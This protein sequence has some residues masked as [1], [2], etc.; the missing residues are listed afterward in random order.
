M[1]NGENSIF[2]ELVYDTG[3]LKSPYPANA[4]FEDKINQ[5]GSTLGIDFIPFTNAPTLAEK[6]MLV[7]YTA[8]KNPIDNKTTMG[9]EIWSSLPERESLP[10]RKP[11]KTVSGQE[12][13]VN[14]K[15][16]RPEFWDGNPETHPATIAKKEKEK[17]DKIDEQLRT[18]E[19]QAYQAKMAAK[20]PKGGYFGGEIMDEDDGRKYITNDDGQKG[21]IQKIEKKIESGNHVAD[22]ITWTNPNT[23]NVNQLYRSTGFTHTPVT[24]ITSRFNDV[25]Q[26]LDDFTSPEVYQEMGKML[27]DNP[28]VHAAGDMAGVVFD[29]LRESLQELSYAAFGGEHMSGKSYNEFMY[30]EF[31][32]IDAELAYLDEREKYY[33]ASLGLSPTGADVAVDVGAAIQAGGKGQ[34]GDVLSSVTDVALIGAAGTAKNTKKLNAIKK[35]KAKLKTKKQAK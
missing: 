24:F 11:F 23:G 25:V 13:N 21:Y 14:E 26:I 19:I 8:E 34:I 22:I 28:V 3:E 4:T 20:K 7:D 16:P 12:T 17:Q 32:S 35:R 29:D 18:E 6:D 2:R 10:E 31:E 33:M 27:I 5:I 9:I 15:M 30:P 1:A